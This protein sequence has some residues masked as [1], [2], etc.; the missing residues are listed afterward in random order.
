MRICF[1]SPGMTDLVC[2]RGDKRIGGSERQQYELASALRN[3][4]VEVEDHDKM[5]K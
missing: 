2:G 1:I 3:I 5:L 4:G